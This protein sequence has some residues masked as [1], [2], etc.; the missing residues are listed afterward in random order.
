VIHGRTSGV[1]DAP[2]FL[3]G[4]D[5]SLAMVEA[6]MTAWLKAHPCACEARCECDD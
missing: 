2:T 3:F 5:P 6:N 1:V 4:P